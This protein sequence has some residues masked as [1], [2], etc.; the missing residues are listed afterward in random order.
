MIEK[1]P[2]QGQRLNLDL[3]K[4]DSTKNPHKLHTSK[5]G[6]RTLRQIARKLA[7]RGYYSTPSEAMKVLLEGV[8][9]WK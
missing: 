4:S 6:Q 8:E 9:S 7:S 1:A 2:T 5:N 3:R